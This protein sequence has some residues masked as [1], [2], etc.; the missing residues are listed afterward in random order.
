MSLQ[1]GWSQI[2]KRIVARIVVIQIL[3]HECTT[4]KTALLLTTRV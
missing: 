1:I 3:S 2:G 4:L